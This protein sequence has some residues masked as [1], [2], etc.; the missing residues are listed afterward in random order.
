MSN[1]LK[2]STLKSGNVL[3]QTSDYVESSETLEDSTIL[4]TTPAAEESASE[5]T[6]KSTK[7]VSGK[8]SKA[9]KAKPEPA[10]PEPKDKATAL[11]I[12]LAASKAASVSRVGPQVFTA[13]LE[14]LE[15][16]KIRHGLPSL[17]NALQCAVAALKDAENL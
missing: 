12:A 8:R 17:K 1:Q 10:T 7:K 11:E 14:F 4:A 13:D 5:T 2:K 16:Y 3:S 15:A 9:T 6:K